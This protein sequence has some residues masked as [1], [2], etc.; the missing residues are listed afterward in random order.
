MNAPANI[1]SGGVAT[2]IVKVDGNPIP[3]V[4]GIL[5]IHI[6]KEI[7][8][9]S[10]AK[11]TIVDGN[12]N[13]AKFKVSSSNT[14]VPGKSVTIEAGY[15]TKNKVIFKGIITGQSIQ[16]NKWV[17]STLVVDCRDE[18][19]KMI[20][21]RKSATY[22]KKTDSEIISSIIAKYSGLSK[23][24]TATKI[25]WPE[26]V[27]CDTSDWDFILS[28]AEVNGLIV[29]TV[30]NK[31]S[32]FKPDAD[33]KSVLTIKFGDNLI[34]LNSDLNCINQ[35]GVVKSSSWDVKTQKIISD[36]AKNTVS[37]PGNISSKK[38]SE[39]IGLK[40]YDLQTSANLTKPELKDWSEAQM[41]K[42]ELSKILGDVKFQGTALV[43]VAKYITL[44]G[45][46]DRFNGDY[47]VSKVVHDISEG[48]WLTT[49]N[50][51]LPMVWFTE[52]QDVMVPPASGLLP[53]AR[54][55][56]NGTV[57]KIYDDPDKQFRILVNIPLFDTKG[58]GIWARLSN[59]YSTSNAGAFFLPEVDDEVV[60]GFLNED[61]RFPIILGSLYS[62]KKNKPFKGLQPNKENSKKAIVSKSGIFIE[63]DD[64]NKVF[65]MTTPG[66]NTVILSDKDKKITMKDSN[67]NLVEMSSGGITIKSPKNINIDA[68]QKVNIKGK[69]GVVAAASGG[70]VKI[71]GVNVKANAKAQF[72]AQGSATAAIKGGAQLKLNAAII[73]IN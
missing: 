47:L 45:C 46:G 53:G 14:F 63:F 54:G 42:S 51:G 69:L 61:P 49:A 64:E 17:G 32:V 68:G 56:M 33:T 18:A 66:K 39:V 20:V 12:V 40:E 13:Y 7:N 70:D 19:V 16:I 4:D 57:K 59:F 72:S 36:T 9:I 50:M 43:D 1:K 67:N 27:Q 24:V 37:G 30:D 34:E 35:L 55:L 52:Q 62:S 26:Q 38:L 23:K 21:G 44:E 41:L 2:F 58:E 31:V 25:V 11:I 73:M 6:E 65:T 8:R 60:V 5:S 15:D 71:D 3:D 10:S 22:Y 28:R 48:N 29:T